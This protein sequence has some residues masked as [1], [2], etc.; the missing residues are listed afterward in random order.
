M[1]SGKD[2]GAED[3]EFYLDDPATWYLVDS[4]QPLEVAAKTLLVSSPYNNRYKDF[5]KHYTSTMRYMPVW[6]WDEIE[7]CQKVLLIVLYSKSC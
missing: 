5:L 4:D 7:S 6:T 2:K 3:L 1:I